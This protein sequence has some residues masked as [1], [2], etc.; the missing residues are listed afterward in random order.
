MQLQADFEKYKCVTDQ[1]LSDLQNAVLH[2]NDTIAFLLD[3]IQQSFSSSH[4]HEHPY[5]LS[6]Q[7]QVVFNQTTDSDAEP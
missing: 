1:K 2:Q 4:N 3:A 6:Q 7:V 5:M